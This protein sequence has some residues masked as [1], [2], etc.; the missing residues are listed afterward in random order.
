MSP[1]ATALCGMPSKRDDS[2]TWATVKPPCSLTARM[3]T[4][5]S[6]PLPE[7]TTATALSPWSSASER[8]KGSTVPGSPRGVVSRKRPRRIVK[9]AL[10]GMM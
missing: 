5:P 10:G 7:S 3:P 8:K 9:V 4:A 6:L 2:T 1:V